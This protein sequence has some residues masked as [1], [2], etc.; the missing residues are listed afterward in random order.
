MSDL[1]DR[2]I[3]MCKSEGVDFSVIYGELKA[4][5]ESY[6]KDEVEKEFKSHQDLVGKCYKHK[7][8]YYKII[9]VKASNSARISCIAFSKH[10]QF[11]FKRVFSKSLGFSEYAG[12]I[13]FEGIHTEDIML[14]T[15]YKTIFGITDFEEITEEEFEKAY[16]NYCEEL[17]KADW[18][19]GD[20][21]D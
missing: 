6:L 5:L 18:R 13:V 9:S 10:P 19:S 12:E 3:Q 2:F 15:Q 20:S 17:L 1:T 16:R 11:Y 4:E 8:K 14:G 7:D 21:G